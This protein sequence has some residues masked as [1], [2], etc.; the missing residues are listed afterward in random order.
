MN[1]ANRASAASYI[2]LSDNTLAKPG[3]IVSFLDHA[4]E[5]VP[6]NTTKSS[7]ALNQ[8]EVSRTDTCI[9]DP[10]Y[11]LL[12]THEWL[13]IVILKDNRVIIYV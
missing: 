2:D 9:D 10:D 11:R 7:V 13:G 1:E 12:I 6:G 8:F 4:N 3:R 5:F